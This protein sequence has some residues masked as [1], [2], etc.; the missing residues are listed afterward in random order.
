MPAGFAMSSGNSARLVAAGK[1]SRGGP[2]T[3]SLAAHAP[4]VPPR[5]ALDADVARINV[6]RSRVVGMASVEESGYRGRPPPRRPLSNPRGR[7]WSRIRGRGP[8]PYSARGAREK[9]RRRHTT[10]ACVPSSNAARVL[11]RSRRDVAPTPAPRARDRPHR[12]AHA[13]PRSR[14]RRTVHR[15]ASCSRDARSSRIAAVTAQ[16]LAPLPMTQ[17]DSDDRRARSDR[18]LVCGRRR[19]YAP[20]ATGSAGAIPECCGRV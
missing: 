7:P 16:R 8:R 3:E 10:R 1:R 17:C 13:G 6:V 9:R 15:L 19:A 20:D 18:V 4:G 14:S 12:G 5:G 11:D 2:S